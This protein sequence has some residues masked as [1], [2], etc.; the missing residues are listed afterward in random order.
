M[1][2]LKKALKKKVKLLSGGVA[3]L[4][5]SQAAKT[6]AKPTFFGDVSPDVADISTRIIKFIRFAG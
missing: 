1:C 2:C 4:I 5:P 6:P 3:I